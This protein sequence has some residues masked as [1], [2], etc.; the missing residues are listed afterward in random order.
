MNLID[1]DKLFTK[2]ASL[3]KYFVVEPYTK[4]YIPYGYY[5]DDILAAIDKMPVIDPERHRIDAFIYE[6]YA[7]KGQITSKQLYQELPNTIRINLPE[8]HDDCYVLIVP[9]PDEDICHR[10]FYLVTPDNPCAFMF[11]CVVSNN[12]EATRL[13]LMNA[14]KYID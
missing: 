13:A 14:P 11:G 5:A 8:P 7:T 9:N 12:F 10:D 2:I 1:K 3:K 4:K 6:R